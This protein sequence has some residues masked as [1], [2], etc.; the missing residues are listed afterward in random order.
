MGNNLKTALKVLLQNRLQA[1]LT[2]CGMSVGVAM[3]VIV[4]G[5][6]LGAQQTIESQIESS[7]PT[8][9]VIRSGNFRPAAI[10]S[11]GGQDSGGGEVSE[12]SMS[13]GINDAEAN[14]P[15]AVRQAHQQARRP[16]A[17][18]TNRTPAAPLGDAEMRVVKRDVK[19]VRAIAGGLEGNVS[20]DADSGV[21]VRVVHLQGFEEAWPDMRSWHLA[22][23]RWISSGEHA[24]GAPLAIVTAAVAARLWPGV[25]EPLGGTFRIGGKEI[26]VVG[27][28]APKSEGGAAESTVVPTISVPLAL[29]Q[30]LLDRKTFDTITVRTTSVGVTTA[31]ANDIKARLRT[32]REL[33]D[34]MLEDFRVDTQ[35][36]SAMPSM[37]L[38]PRLA[39]AVH[40]NVVGFEQA[41]WE[42]MARSL[43]QAGRTF[44][45][46]L[47][48]AAAVS[49]VVGGIGVMNI[50][51]VS[52]AARTREIGLRIA[53]GASTNDVMVQFLVEA[54]TLAALGGLIGLVL[55][56]LG[57][58]LAKYGLHWATALSPGMLLLAVVM[59]AVT[60][61]AFGFG[62]ARRAAVLDPVTALR[63]E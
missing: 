13:D 3:V 50:M 28:L 6:G 38:D 37:G 53:V 2:L 57:L 17:A 40:S 34:N 4:S 60:G 33:P 48:A 56:S 35:S 10:V 61:I 19:N 30:M 25:A 63:A 47:A 62:P 43:R 20:V 44:T 23:G 36:V 15:A 7:G 45:L 1:L 29:A 18:L 51:L 14:L 24:N 26:R 27:V 21:P 55:G 42:E 31:V 8:Q 41:S 22:A 58:M 39:R 32:L 52:V 9:I 46:L 11:S 49:L 16:S 59:A 54:V 12:G 5:L